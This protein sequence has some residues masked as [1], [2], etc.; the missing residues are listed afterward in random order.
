MT[1]IYLLVAALGWTAF[2]AW[3][4]LFSTRKLPLSTWRVPVALAVFAVV[5]PLP[6]VDELV[7][8]RQFEQLCQENS[9]IQVDR[10][11]AAG[12]TVYLAKTDDMEI[13]GT[14]VRVVLQPRRFVDATTGEAVVS[15]NELVADGGRFVRAIG[16]SEGGVPLTFKGWCQP[17]DQYALDRLLKELEITQ[18]RRPQT[19]HGEKK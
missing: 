18:V 14:W 7:G 6:L 11:S 15:H 9:T 1:G 3:L 8:K 4:S 17:G 12:R 16:I 5:L 19:N 2:V 13:K 10:A